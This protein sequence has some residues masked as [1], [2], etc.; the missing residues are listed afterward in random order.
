[1][2]ISQQLVES[3]DNHQAHCKNTLYGH[4]FINSA[5][6]WNKCMTVDLYF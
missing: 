4:I 2:V 3:L 5:E 6:F 1:M